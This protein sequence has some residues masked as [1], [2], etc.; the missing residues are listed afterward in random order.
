MN[1]TSTGRYSYES[2][3][4]QAKIGSVTVVHHSGPRS[5]LMTLLSIRVQLEVPELP[6]TS[7]LTFEAGPPG[8]SKRYGEALCQCP[9]LTMCVKYTLA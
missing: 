7:R 3:A 2:M 9:I 1:E 4:G 8:G 5:C 6:K